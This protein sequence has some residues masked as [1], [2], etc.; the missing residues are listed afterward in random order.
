MDVVA[1]FRKKL[2][3]FAGQNGVFCGGENAKNGGLLVE[4]AGFW[5]RA[6]FGLSGAGFHNAQDL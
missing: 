5:E 2:G 4:K 1:Q 6:E 3:R